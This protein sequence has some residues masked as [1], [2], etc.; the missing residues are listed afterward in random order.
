M[1]NTKYSNDVIANLSVTK[2]YI[3][4]ACDKLL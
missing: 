4:L 3:I 1:M 2:P